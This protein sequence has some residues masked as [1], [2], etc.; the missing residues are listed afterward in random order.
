MSAGKAP[1]KRLPK[2]GEPGSIEYRTET[3]KPEFIP[4]DAY[5]VR[6]YGWFGAW[7]EARWNPVTCTFDIRASDAM[8]LLPDTSNSMKIKIGSKP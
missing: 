4:A 5:C 7:V 6:L 2:P 8:V 3:Y 1:K